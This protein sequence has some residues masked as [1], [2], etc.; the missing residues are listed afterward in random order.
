MSAV[1]QTLYETL[2]GE[3]TIGKVVDVFYNKYVLNDDRIKDFFVGV[4]M[5]KQRLMQTKFLAFAFGGPAFNGKKMNVAHRHLKLKD[6]HFDAVIDDLGK[7]LRDFDVSDEIIAKIVAVAETTRDDVLG[8][9][10]K[11]APVVPEMEHVDRELLHTDPIYRFQ[12][13]AKF[14]D[15][16]DKDVEAIKSVAEQL[17][18]L[19]SVLVD[20]V[21][22]KLHKFDVTWASMAKRHEGY[23]GQVV[24]NVD[25]LGVDSS[26]I[27][28]R[29]DMLTRYI[30]RLLTNPYDE[31]MIKYLDW[32][33]KIHT[34][35]PGKQSKINVEYIH[36]S[37]LL[38]FVESTLI[39]AISTLKLEREHELRVILAFNKVL[40]LQNDFFAKYYA[41][42]GSDVP[43]SF[44][45]HAHPPKSKFS[46]QSAIIGGAVAAIGFLVARRL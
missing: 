5:E 10:E 43:N 2:G 31:R 27:K 21:Y 28:Y 39:W 13:V 22:D 11:S 12:Y 36:I 37:A 34:D 6:E 32:V 42:D 3:E 33:A 45:L 15:F 16:S 19:G 41:K 38:G 23:S 26:Q 18:P 46:L 29:K 44:G 14:V 9:T 8:R 35:I 25:D 7:A 17:A 30:G 24:E 1:E 40:W 20:A 4:D